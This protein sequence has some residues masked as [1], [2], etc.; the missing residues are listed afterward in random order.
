MPNV[1]PQSHVV[2]RPLVCSG[3]SRPV[4]TVA[5]SALNEADQSFFLL[6]SCL[7]GKAM[8]RVGN[9]G[10]WIGTF[11]GHKGS[12]WSAK[13]TADASHALTGSADYTAKLWSAETGDALATFEHKHIVRAV[14]FSLDGT[15]AVTGGQEKLLRVF[16]LENYAAEPV[17]LEGHTD[18]IRRVLWHGAHTLLSCASDKTIRL[19]D[20]RAGDAVQCTQL[21]TL[22]KDI[23]I[24]VGGAR[25]TL[26]VTGGKRVSFFDA[27][28]LSSL[29]AFDYP[30]AL[31]SAALNEKTNRFVAGGEDF[32]AKV[33]DYHTGDVLEV[34]K[35][36][37]GPV[38]CVRYSPDLE[39]FASSSEDG[40]VRLWQ[41]EVKDYG[42]WVRNETLRANDD[43]GASVQ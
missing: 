30:F 16:D 28:D 2:Q 32:W 3:H 25:E 21:D 13:L 33:F 10:D 37:H 26:T 19:W 4:P 27:A 8:L 41:C 5:F 9:T 20:L 29:K 1:E 6:T 11:I 43:D 17:V 35:G 12:V 14:D 42:L 40:T 36:H 38:H 22:I 31:N 39:L 34:H 24:S 23:S 15:H 7:D 18:A